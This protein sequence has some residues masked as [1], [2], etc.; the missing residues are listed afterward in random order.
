M[1]KKEITFEETQVK[2]S[3]WIK[4]FN[5]KDKYKLKITNEIRKYITNMGEN[6]E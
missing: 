5:S 3:F 4:D 6:D 2:V 1:T